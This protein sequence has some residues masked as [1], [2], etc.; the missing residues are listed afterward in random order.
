V[1]D[2]IAQPGGE[3]TAGDRGSTVKKVNVRITGMVGGLWGGKAFT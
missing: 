3:G 1:T 2:V